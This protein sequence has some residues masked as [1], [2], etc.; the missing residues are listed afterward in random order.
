MRRVSPALRPYLA[1]AIA[2]AA[3][4]PPLRERGEDLRSK[5]LAGLSRGGLALR[6]APLGIEQAAYEAL[7]DHP[8]F[9]DVA[10]LDVLLTELAARA[11]GD[12]VRLADVVAIGVS[13][14]PVKTAE[15]A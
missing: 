1:D 12:L 14:P 10:E 7:A 15:S 5:V 4:W 13:A 3:V 2:D 8:F 11:S 6:G 9:G